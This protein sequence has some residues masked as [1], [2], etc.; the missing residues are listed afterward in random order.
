M[1][2]TY[3]WEGDELN[4]QPNLKQGWIFR[5]HQLNWATRWDQWGERNPI[6]GR[7]PFL[8]PK[9][10]CLVHHRRSGK[11]ELL[12]YAAIKLAYNNPSNLPNS[13]LPPFIIGFCYPEYQAVRS[14]IVD[15]LRFLSIIPEHFLW[16]GDVNKALHKS[17][18]RLTF[19]N[20]TQ[21]KFFGSDQY[22]SLRGHGFG[23]LLI[24]E[25]QSAKD[26]AWQVL[27]PMAAER[28]CITNVTCGTPQ[29]Y[30]HLKSRFDDYFRCMTAGS[31]QINP[32][33]NQPYIVNPELYNR[34]IRNGDNPNNYFAELLSVKDTWMWDEDP[35]SP[36][37]SQQI[38]IMNEMAIDTDRRYYISK[39]GA[40]IAEIKIQQE[41]YCSWMGGGTFPVYAMELMSLMESVDGDGLPY[42]RNLRAPN[43]RGVSFPVQGQPVHL[44]WD[45]GK[46]EFS[47]LMVVIAFQTF[48]QPDGSMDIVVL[49]YIADNRQHYGFYM[50]WAQSNNYI[51][52]Y[53]IMPHDLAP[54]QF[55]GDI[56]Q[57]FYDRGWTLYTL[58]QSPRRAGEEKVRQ[59]FSSK[60]VWFD[61]RCQLDKAGAEYGRSLLNGLRQYSLKYDDNTGSEKPIPGA[62]ENHFG[63]AFRYLAIGAIDIIP[64][65][66]QDKPPTPAE[67]DG[68][69]Y[70]HPDGSFSVHVF[71]PELKKSRK[72]FNLRS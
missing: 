72:P 38:P 42:I 43:P 37:Y 16:K 59:I 46:K 7:R 9:N 4:A 32:Q 28:S 18:L 49:D 55:E 33:T 29:G 34:L 58:P 53:S 66:H 35:Y 8:G 6:T 15:S 10:N 31:T 40:D 30:N 54:L 67:L 39:H 13:P 12:L 11:D 17:A 57:R 24:D 62:W 22:E 25:W 51:G 36:T 26:E 45:L 41:Y 1:K 19:A 48:Y 56:Y 21:L 69:A 61:T 71:D 52:G 60:S 70:S 63:D 65:K 50:D 3:S 44:A 68:R 5:P 2:F 64:S 47:D 23:A 27:G 20:E 14:S